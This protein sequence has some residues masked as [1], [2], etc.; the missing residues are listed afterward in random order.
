MGYIESTHYLQN[1]VLAIIVRTEFCLLFQREV[2][3]KGGKASKK[4]WN[5]YQSKTNNILLNISCKV[6]TYCPHVL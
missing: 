5:K 1:S 4:V 3:G 6:N 2:G